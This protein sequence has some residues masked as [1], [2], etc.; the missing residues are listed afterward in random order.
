MTTEIVLTIMILI[1]NNKD[2]VSIQYIVCDIKYKYSTI[3]RINLS[4]SAGPL[5]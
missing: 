4:I 3:V 1:N 2:V 5:L